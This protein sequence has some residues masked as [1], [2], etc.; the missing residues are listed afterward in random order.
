MPLVFAD[1]GEDNIIKRITGNNEVKQRLETLGFVPGATV[2]I[3]SNNNGNFIVNIKETR[4]A[5]STEMA[6]MIMV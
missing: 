1:S 2:R 6:Q 5:I 4:M 3:I